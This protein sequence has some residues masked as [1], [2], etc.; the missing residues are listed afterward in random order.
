VL[1]LFC[2]LVCLDVSGY[3]KSGRVCYWCQAI[4]D[5]VER[6]HGLLDDHW[7]VVLSQLQL[8][9]WPI[10]CRDPR[11]AAVHGVPPPQFVRQL[12]SLIR[13]IMRRLSDRKP[14]VL[15]A[16]ARKIEWRF[17]R[18]LEALD[19]APSMRKRRIKI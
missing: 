12:D 9:R 15:L 5:D 17:P 7:H 13:E 18:L 19:A 16:V 14:E 3:P 8:P 4:T 10:Y 11:I 2:G 6:L 1:A